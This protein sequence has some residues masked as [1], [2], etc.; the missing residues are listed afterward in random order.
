MRLEVELTDFEV[1]GEIR[2]LLLQLNE[3]EDGNIE[4]SEVRGGLPRRVMFSL[5]LPDSLP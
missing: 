1:A 2:R 3:I 5:R 4:R